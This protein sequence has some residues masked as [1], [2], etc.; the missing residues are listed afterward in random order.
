MDGCTDP[1]VMALGQ[2][3]LKD[4]AATSIQFRRQVHL[5]VPTLTIGTLSAP[6]QPSDLLLL[7]KGSW[8]N[9]TTLVLQQPMDTPAVE[10]LTRGELPL[11]SS[12]KICIQNHLMAAF[13]QLTKGKWPML[14]KLNLSKT[15]LSAEAM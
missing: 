1:L 15:Y 12:L 6:S 4:L 8:R 3:H 2:S 11:L 13:A 7:A 14:E 5:F 10:Y 9:L